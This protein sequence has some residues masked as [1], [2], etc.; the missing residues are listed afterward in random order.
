MA[1]E[2]DGNN[3]LLNEHGKLVQIKIPATVDFSSNL[4]EII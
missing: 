3:I 2:Q 4:R 1:L